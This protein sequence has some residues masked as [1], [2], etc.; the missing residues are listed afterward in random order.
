MSSKAITTR[1]ELETIKNLVLDA[2]NSDKS[3]RAYGRALD[4]F[5]DWYFKSGQPQLTKAVV[6]RYKVEVL[7]KAG[8]APATI[9]QALSAI[10]KLA[11]EAADNQYMPQELANGIGKIKGVDSHGVRSGNWLTK[12]QAQALINAPDINEIKGLRD[13]AILAVM[14]GAGLRRSEVAELTFDHI[15]QREGR[16]VIVDLVSK[17]NRVRTVPIPSWTKQAIDEWTLTARISSGRIFRGVF[18]YGH[19]LQPESKKITDQ[20]IFYVVEAACAKA[21]DATGDEVFLSISPHDLRRSYARLARRGGSDMAQIQLTLGHASIKTTE[22][23]IGE[24]LDLTDAP[25]D[26]LGLRL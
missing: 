11:S 6:N 12:D 8:L 15:Q 24:Q 2:L 18:R 21:Y 5:L 22:R 1:N 9:N 13:R 14:L 4:R 20:V 26:H 7:E 19:K 3:R 17:G 10:R 25:C 23:Y 16:W